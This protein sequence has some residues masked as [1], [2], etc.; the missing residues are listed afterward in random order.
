VSLGSIEIESCEDL[1]ALRFD[2]YKFL[3]EQILLLKVSGHV[4]QFPL[5]LVGG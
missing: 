5:V 1:C 3:M 4:S 2:I